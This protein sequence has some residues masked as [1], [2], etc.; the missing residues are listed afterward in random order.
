MKKEYTWFMELKNS[1]TRLGWNEAKQT[2]ECSNDWWNEHLAKCNNPEKG[3]KCNHVKFRKQGPKHLDDLHILFEKVH[4]TGASASCPGNIFSDES[5][6]DDVAEVQKT[7]ESDDMKLAELKKAKPAKKKRKD[8][9]TATEEKDEKSPFFRLYKNTCKRIETAADKILSG[10][11]RR[12]N[13]DRHQ[14]LD[15]NGL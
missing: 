1:D 12:E 8:N 13:I 6:D 2:V 7:P 9:S 5:S 11:C 10:I 4:V 14:K 3:I 15:F